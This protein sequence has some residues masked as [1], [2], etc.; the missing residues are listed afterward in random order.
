MKAVGQKP[1]AMLILIVFCTLVNRVAFGQAVSGNIEGTVT[2]PSEAAIP[3]AEVTIRDLDR[4]LSYE[5]KTNTDG[6]YVQTHLLAGHY[7]VQ[8]RAPG[9]AEFLA[10][11]VV[12]VDATARVDAALT[13]QKAGTE[14]TVTAE[15]PL[16][17]M[18]RP[19]V[20]ANLTGGEIDKLPVLDRNLTQLILI[21]PGAQENG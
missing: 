6:N 18:D 11:V 21:M 3:S 16:M 12:Q 4:G 15:A 9:F 7:E 14:V 10:K 1:L 8:V 5:T 13:I 19:E 20:S 2:D 17:K